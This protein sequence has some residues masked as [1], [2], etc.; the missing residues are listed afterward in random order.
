MQLTILLT[1]LVLGMN[2]KWALVVVVVNSGFSLIDWDQKYWIVGAI[3]AYY[4][5]SVYDKLT[6]SGNEHSKALAISVGMGLLV[7]GFTYLG[8]TA[9]DFGLGYF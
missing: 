5:S 9:L 8:A 4:C 3:T 6:K 7:A 1:V 2:W